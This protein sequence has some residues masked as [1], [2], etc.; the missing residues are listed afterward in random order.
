MFQEIDY[1]QMFG[2]I[3]KWV[4]QIDRPDRIDGYVSRAFHIAQLGRRW[5]RPARLQPAE[6][7]LMIVGGWSA[8]AAADL[9]WFA[10]RFELLVGT[11]FRRQDYFDDRH[12]YYA[13]N[14]GIGINLALA[15]KV[16]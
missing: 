5:R 13:G 12:P 6:T 3:V 4:A 9:A 10:V 11:A 14:I 7:L 15:D 8:Q 2:S 1:G 16:K